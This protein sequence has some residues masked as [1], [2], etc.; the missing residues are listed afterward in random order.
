MLPALTPQ[1]ASPE[2]VRGEPV[3]TVSDVYSLGVLLYELLTGSRP[4]AV[5]AESMEEIVRAVC[6]SEPPPPSRAARTNPTASELKG[7]LD[8]IVQRALR[9]EPDRRYASAREL[10]EDIRRYLDGRPVLAEQ[11]LCRFCHGAGA[12]P[13]I[14]HL[15]GGERFVEPARLPGLKM[16]PGSQ[17]G[18]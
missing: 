13:I 14:A 18:I 5:K 10:A 1:Y 15:R 7:D 9:K 6:E 11:G 3:T 17:Q 2:H 12:A 8:T 4:Y 16:L